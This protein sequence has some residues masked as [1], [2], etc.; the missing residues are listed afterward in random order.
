MPPDND[1]RFRTLFEQAPFSVQLLA[2]DGRTLA[3]N[4]AWEAMWD[5]E[6]EHRMKTLVLDGYN[7]LMDPQLETKGI[8]PYLRRAFAGEAVQ[9]PAICYDPGDVGLPGRP[10]WVKA[11][12]HPIRD[13]AGAVCEVMLIHEDV[14]AQVES[15]EALRYGE[16]RLRQ[17]AD[18]IPQPAWMSEADGRVIWYN[19]QWY[20]Y[21][22]IDPD[23]EDGYSWRRAAHPDEMKWMQDVRNRSVATGERVHITANLKGWDDVY[24]PFLILIAPLKDA[25]GQIRHW[26]GTA[27][28]I[29]AV[30]A[31]Q[32]DLRVAEERLRLATEAGDIGIWEWDTASGRII[33]SDRI[34]DIH[35]VDRATFVLNV[36]NYTALIHPEDL[37]VLWGQVETALAD[38]SGFSLEFRA[39]LPDGGVRW[40]A[41]WARVERV[42]LDGSQRL[43]GAVLNIDAHKIAE[44]ALRDGSRRKDEFLA[45]L[46]HELRNPLAPIAMSA[47][48]LRLPRFDEARVR[49]TAE[50]ISRQVAHMTELID[51]LMD[52]SR[53]TRGLVQLDRGLHDL[54]ALAMTAVEQVRPLIETRNHVLK[55]HMEA[56]PVHVDGDRTRLVQILSNLLNNA[57]KYTPPGGEIGL[58]VAVRGRKAVVTVSDSGEG[59][60]ADLLPF[61]FDLFTQGPRTLDRSQGGLGIGLA[62]VKS[63]VEMHDGTVE[64]KSD[65][66][67]Q[68][69]TFTVVLPL[70]L[71]AQMPA[72]VTPSGATAASARRLVVVDDN[73]DAAR[74]LAMLLEANGHTVAVFDHA[75]AVLEAVEKLRPDVFILDIGLPDM[76]G[77]DLARRLRAMPEFETATVIALTGYGQASDREESTAAGFDHHLVKPADPRKLEAI[78]A[79]IGG[80]EEASL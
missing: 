56:G 14:T 34:Y 64:A 59:I 38:N 76:T 21:T 45:M 57:A 53:V 60:A 35:G 67:G 42:G 49:Q 7:V 74:S 12:A 8:T 19:G 6:G 58:D 25:Q 75:R 1:L 5:S 32:K 20:D 73:I 36:E 46:A 37:P 51:D 55:T 3:V 68:G 33:W 11:S 71:T 63:L 15:E 61:V 66:P 69:T 77:Y 26:F 72:A 23:S 28:D 9:I 2:A 29:S 39:V 50:V 54:K 52:V 31:A 78:L 27:T 79:G 41:T 40:L 62:L 30:H 48:L 24:R 80:E 18:S 44:Q 16:E 10:R 70:D 22:G 43:I 17:L 4:H 65:G 47:D 13:E